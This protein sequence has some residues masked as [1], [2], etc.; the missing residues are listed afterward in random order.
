MTTLRSGPVVRRGASW[1]VGSP[2]SSARPINRA[3]SRP[4]ST[5]GR[6]AIT[7]RPG[8]PGEVADA[9]PT[10]S[11][12]APLRE[13]ARVCPRAEGRHARGP[14]LETFTSVNE[15]DVL[16]TDLSTGCHLEA[17]RFQKEAA[18]RSERH[19]SLV[20][21]GLTDRPCRL[22]RR[23]RLGVTCHTYTG[24]AAASGCSSPQN[25]VAARRYPAR[26]GEMRS[27]ATPSGQ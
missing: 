14:V 2:S 16:S 1:P 22:L 19:N 10:A 25:A 7:R 20:R 4:R 5:S 23:T 27:V 8:G 24:C 21:S 3:E 12:P 9:K 6:R 17:E 18:V 11:D 26:G 13:N 15:N